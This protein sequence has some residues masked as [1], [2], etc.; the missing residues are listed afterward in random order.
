MKNGQWEKEDLFKFMEQ[1]TAKMI[2]VCKEKNSD[3]TGVNASPFANFELVSHYG[4]S[5]EWG[6]FTRLSDK[7]SRIASFI[8]NVQLQVKDESVEDTIIDMA[9]YLLLFAAYLRSKRDLKSFQE[10]VVEI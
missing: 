5:V 1:K 4:G 10:T 2:Q 3:Y 9:N 8:S 6:F 7:F